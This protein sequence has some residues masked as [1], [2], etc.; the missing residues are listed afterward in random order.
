MLSGIKLAELRR[1]E[2]TLSLAKRGTLD[3]D[4]ILHGQLSG[5]PDKLQERLKSR[6][7]FVPAA[8]KLLIDLFE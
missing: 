8:Q 5:S 1:L 3:P 2:A 4:H 7:P 6:S